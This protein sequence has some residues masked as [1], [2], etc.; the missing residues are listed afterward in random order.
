MPLSN[1]YRRLSVAPMA[2]LEQRGRGS[3]GGGGPSRRIQ[4]SFP[5]GSHFIQGTHPFFGLLSQFHPGQSLSAGGVS[6][7]EGSHRT[8]STSFA[9]LLQPVIC[10]D[11]DLGVVA[12]SGRSFSSEPQSVENTFKMETLQSTLL[13]VRRGDWMV[14]IDLKDAYLQVPIHPESRKYLR[15]M[16]FDKVYQFKVLCFGLSTAPQVFTRVMA[17]VSAILHSLSIR[18]QRYLDDWLIQASSREQVLLALRIVLRLCNSLGIVVSWEKSQLVPTQ[19]ICYLGVLLDSINFRASPAQKRVDKLLS[20]GDVFLSSV[21][22]PAKSWLELLG[23]LSS[24]TQLIPGGRLRMRSF[25]FALH[26]AWDRMDPEALMQWSPEIYQDLLWWLNRERLER[27]IS[28]EQVSPQLDL[29]S[30][31]SDVGWGAH[32]GEEVISGLWSP[33]ERLSS[34]NHREL[35]AVFYALQHFLP[36][37]RNTSVAVFADNTTALAYLKNQGGTRSAV[38]NRMAQDL[39]R[40]AE[41]HSV[42][43][44]PQFIMGRNNVLADALSHP[45]QI[46]GS[47]WTLKLSVFQ[48]L[49]RRWPVSIDLFATS[50]NHRCLPYF[51]PFCDPNSIGTDALLQ[52]WDGWQAYAF[53]PYTLI[54]AIL[55]KLRSSSGV[56]LTI[57]APYWP[58]RPWFPELL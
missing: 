39:L 22:Q 30:D 24:L 51:S 47:E 28:L 37:V 15:F 45:D 4:H 2:H 11:E 34:I 54:P 55:K 56:L 40:W 36:L 10:C 20:I 31:A 12:T 21:E 3:L 48:Q 19:M 44:L 49:R 46:L 6:A 53:P 1:R 27:G 9:G 18:L 42:T 52:P 17:P 33:K 23:V 58:Q 8:G 43:L 14:S 32:P 7:S 25:Q 35:L 16:A 29:W 50:L 57:I 38:L 26:R 41:F 5:E 13:S